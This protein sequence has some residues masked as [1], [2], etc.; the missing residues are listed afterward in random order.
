MFKLIES[1]RLAYLIVFI[2]GAF[3]ALAFSPVNFYFLAILSPA[4]LFY[5]LQRHVVPP[6]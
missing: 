3:L 2:A 4:V 5:S 1:S 6:G